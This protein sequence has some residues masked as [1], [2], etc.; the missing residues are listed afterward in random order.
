MSSQHEFREMMAKN[1]KLLY[2]RLNNSKLNY[3]ARAGRRFYSSIFFDCRTIM[4]QDKRPFDI[5][6]HFRRKYPTIPMSVQ[7]AEI[8]NFDSNFETGNIFSVHKVGR[9]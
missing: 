3:F 2:L 4:N 1:S 6:E 9:Q 8:L 7:E 5:Y